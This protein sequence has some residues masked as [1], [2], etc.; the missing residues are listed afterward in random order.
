MSS[1]LSDWNNKLHLLAVLQ[2]GHWQLICVPY[3]ISRVVFLELNNSFLR[4][5]P[6]HFWKVSAGCYLGTQLRCQGLWLFFEWLLQLGRLISS[7]YEGGS[8]MEVRPLT[9][10]PEYPIAQKHNMPGL[11]SV[12]IF[13]RPTF[14][15]SAFS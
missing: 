1:K 10:W 5:P 6:S 11:L 4:W 12:L 7:Q 15:S 14:N 9:C 8:L 13:N 2:L 3:G